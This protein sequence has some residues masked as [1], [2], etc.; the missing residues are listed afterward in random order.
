MADNL[1]RGA[2]ASVPTD[3][4]EWVLVPREPTREMVDA[5]DDCDYPAAEYS[6]YSTIPADAETHYRAMLAAAPPAPATELFAE[7]A[8]NPPVPT[9][10]G[11]AEIERALGD[12]AKEVQ[13]LNALLT[14]ASQRE[15]I[16]REAKSF[17]GKVNTHLSREN[18]CLRQREAALREA[19]EEIASCDLRYPGDVVS[20]ARAALATNTGE[21][22]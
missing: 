11:E 9:Q 20:I 1:T 13:R 12:A 19:L 14:V 2:S 4:S 15:A 18:E 3:K 5:G 22:P 21:R 10:A 16:M 8:K 6:V 17:L 7:N